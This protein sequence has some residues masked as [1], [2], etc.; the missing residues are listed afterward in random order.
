MSAAEH[1]ARG[2]RELVADL[3]ADMGDQFALGRARLDQRRPHE[4]AGDLLAQGFAEGPDAVLGQLVD[5]TAGA[6][7]PARDGADV[8]EVRDAPRLALGGGQQVRERRV[9]D[10]QQ[11]LEVERDHPV[12][13]LDRGVDD[14]AEQHHAGVV[15]DD[16]EP[17]ELA[18]GALDGGDGLV[19]VGDVGLDR[20]AADLRGEPVQPV[21][22]P[23]GDGDGRALLGERARRRLPDAAAGPR[24]QRDRV[25]QCLRHAT[26]IRARVARP[27]SA[28]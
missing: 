10:V 27:G 16:V 20:E 21:L 23:R 18:R 25:P 6:D 12:P 11:A 8:H 22:A 5:P 26:R 19:P 2:R 3:L 7:A 4:A 1:L 17:A 9:G 13:L 28:A 15:D 24:D 14:R